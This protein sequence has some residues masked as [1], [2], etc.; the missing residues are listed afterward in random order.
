MTSRAA[1]PLLLVLA[2]LLTTGFSAPPPPPDTEIDWR[3]LLVRAAQSAEDLTYVGES[4]SITY[5]GAEASVSTF[6]VRSGGNGRISVVDEERYAVHLGPE[7]GNLADHQRGWFFPLPATA[8]GGQ[9][10]GPLEE[11]YHVDVLPSERLLDRPSTPLEIRRRSDG[12]VV[13]KLWLDDASGLLLRRES[14]VADGEIAAPAGSEAVGRRGDDR[15]LL[16][17]VTYLKLDLEPDARTDTSGR[18][19]RA[20]A[21]P[22]VPPAPDRMRIGRTGQEA[23]LLAGWVIPKE[24]PGGY[25][26]RGAFAVTAQSSQPLQ[27]TYSDGL[28][29]VSLFEQRGSL[30]VASLPPGAQI[31]EAHGFPAYTWPGA[32][33]RRVVWEANGTTWSVVGDAPAQDYDAI[34]SSLPGPQAVADPLADRLSRG[35]GR[36]WS[37]VSPWS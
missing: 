13:E 32:V 35:L 19:S 30:D 21:A 4:L 14:Y 29:T 3:D 17:M 11:K 28:Y 2:L 36:L 15:Q 26:K 24:L 5:E 22:E 34:V 8:P 37:W 23:L 12:Q 1:R 16:R 31:T 7:G 18:P 25:V 6:F 27:L 20:I 9:G 33:P 10:L